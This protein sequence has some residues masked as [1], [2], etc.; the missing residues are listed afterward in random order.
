M[1]SQAE[2]RKVSSQGAEGGPA[3]EVQ[4]TPTAKSACLELLCAWDTGKPNRTTWV[5]RN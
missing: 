3:G 2:S 1:K 5:C 4:S